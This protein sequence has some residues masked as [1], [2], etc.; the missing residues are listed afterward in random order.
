MLTS[1]KEKGKIKK[2][3]ENDSLTDQANLLHSNT[4]TTSNS[5]Q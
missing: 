3:K 4:D 2:K 1:S 5:H